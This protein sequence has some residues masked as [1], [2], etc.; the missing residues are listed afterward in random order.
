ME[1]KSLNTWFR[2]KE[3]VERGEKNTSY[4]W[5]HP[6]TKNGCW[7]KYKMQLFFCVVVGGGEGEAV[8]LF[9]KKNKK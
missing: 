9:Y 4:K 3:Q 8:L 1:W 7:K 2:G 5:E 6:L